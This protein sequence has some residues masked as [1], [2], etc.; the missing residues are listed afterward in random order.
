MK[1]IITCLFVLSVLLIAGCGNNASQVESTV[2]NVVEDSVEEVGTASVDGEDKSPEENESNETDIEISEAVKKWMD[3]YLTHTYS[4]SDLG[5]EF[6]YGGGKV[7]TETENS[8]QDRGK[9]LNISVFGLSATFYSSDFGVAV[10]E[11]CCSG[12]SGPPLDLSKSDIEIEAVLEEEYDEIL[13]LKRVTIGGKQGVSFYTLF[14]YIDSRLSKKVLIPWDG[15]VYTNLV[16]SGPLIK[17]FDFL[18]DYYDDPDNVPKPN[19]ETDVLPKVEEFLAN[20]DLTFD[21]VVEDRWENFDPMVTTI[22][23]TGE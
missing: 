11:G 23:F 8:G 18:V 17:T 5:F 16:L 20:T 14:T 10:G 22:K 4:N 3:E 15:E 7:T 6:R 1:K 13:G 2:E 9:M 12:Y 19:F 21:G